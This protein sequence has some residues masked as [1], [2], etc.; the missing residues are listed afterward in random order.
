[1]R[2]VYQAENILDAHLVRGAL[3]AHGLRAFVTGEFLTGAAGQLPAAG[4]V[5]VLVAD[6]DFAA[7]EIVVADIASAALDPGTP[8]P[9]ARNSAPAGGRPD[10][11]LFCGGN[12]R[13]ILPQGSGFHARPVPALSG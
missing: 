13:R 8:H 4:L 10:H 2:P 12:R 7:A 11:A 3:E 5:S 6:A 9:G 1:M